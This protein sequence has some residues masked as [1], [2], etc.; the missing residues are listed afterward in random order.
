MHVDDEG[1]MS[2]KIKSVEYLAVGAGTVFD[3]PTNDLIYI[4]IHIR[5]QNVSM[6][7]RRVYDESPYAAFPGLFWMVVFFNL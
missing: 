6:C 5:M 1:E 3:P 4:R 2:P 7:I